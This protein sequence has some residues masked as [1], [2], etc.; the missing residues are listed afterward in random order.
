MTGVHYRLICYYQTLAS[1]LRRKRRRRREGQTDGGQGGRVQTRMKD[2]GGGEGRGK[3]E[4][5][6]K[7]GRRRCCSAEK[8]KVVTVRIVGPTSRHE[9]DA[10]LLFS[11]PIPLNL[12][13]DTII[14]TCINQLS[15]FHNAA[16]KPLNKL[17]PQTELPRLL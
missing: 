16:D 2:G 15:A 6:Q 14:W 9:G 1:W 13:N 10:E 12:I 17:R 4:K 11:P 7:G 8:Y 3:D 5:P